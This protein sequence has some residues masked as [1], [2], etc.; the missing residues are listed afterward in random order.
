M[1]SRSAC[2]QPLFDKKMTKTLTA[3]VV[4]SDAALRHAVKEDELLACF[5]AML[6]L[7][8]HLQEP[9]LFVAACQRME[10]DGDASWLHG[11]TTLSLRSPGTG[12]RRILC[13]DDSCM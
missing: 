1:P 4:A 13:L 5:P 6:E 9:Q 12:C 7:R 11:T 8:P 3:H 10:Q 2:V